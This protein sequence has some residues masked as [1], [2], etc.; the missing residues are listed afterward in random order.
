MVFATK[1]E[2]EQAALLDR[3]A[4]VPGFLGQQRLFGLQVLEAGTLNAAGNALEADI[5]DFVGQTHRF[6]QLGTTIGRD[7]G[8]THLRQDLQQALGNTLAVV[9][10]GFVQVANDFAGTDQVTQHFIR[11]VRVDCG[12]T[13]ADQH[14]VVMR[15]TGGRGFN[16]DVALATQ[17]RRGHVVMHST[18]SQRRVDRQLALLD[19][20]VAQHDQRLAFTHGGLGLGGDIAHGLAKRRAFSDV[21]VNDV[22]REAG[23]LVQVHDGA[24]LG[25]RDHRRAENRAIGVIGSLFKDVALGTQAGFQRHD[26]GFTQRVDRRIGHLGELLTEVVI[27]RTHATG[28]HRHR[29]VVAHGTDRF[30]TVLGQRAQH[31][32]T[33]FEGDLEHLHVLLETLGRKEIGA[34]V[35]IIQRSLDAQGI[36]LQPLAVRMTGLQAISHIIG[37]QYFASLSVDSQN[38]TR[39]NTA[40]AD[41]VFGLVV[42]HADFGGQGDIAVLGDDITRRAQT[43]AVEQTDRVAT[44]GQYN[45]GRAVPGFHMHGVVFVE[46]PQ[47]GIHGL[48]VLPRRRHDHADGAEQIHAAADQQL[49][50]VVHARGVGTGGVD[51]RGQA[52]QIGHQIVGELVTARLGPV[53]VGGDGVDFTIVGNQ[54]ERLRQRPLRQG[55][56]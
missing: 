52:V 35:A 43:V 13:E 15:I 18:D 53:T 27:D 39:T 44:F 14:R 32:V 17:T 29:R 20:P 33:L 12:R 7:G 45:T 36:F 54:T 34:V 49:K 37:V 24:P 3:L 50:H 40:L 5:N 16:Q 46:R 21:E 55:I 22:A 31:L 56:G 23:T 38:L 28:Q 25:R 8:D 51:Q 41:D 42:P 6:K 47:I 30:L 9:L 19:S 4:R 10:E 26:D 11:Q 2:L 1:H 48:H